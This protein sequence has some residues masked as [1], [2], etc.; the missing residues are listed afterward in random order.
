MKSERD[1]TLEAVE[2]AVQMEIDGKKF[3]QKA[4]KECDNKVAKRLY[5]WLATEEEGH[6]RTFERIYAAIKDKKGWPEISLQP[7][8]AK[9]LVTFFSA[10]RESACPV[11]EAPT[12]ELE[13]AAKAMDMENKTHEFYKSRGAEAAYDAE[14]RLYT[15]LAAEEQ[16]HYLALVDYREYLIDPAGW[17]RKAE[18]HS[19]DGG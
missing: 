4:S 12:T 9:T 18:H 13:V 8:E 15:S 6:R 17:F 5:D 19:L 7:K 2:F 1:R 14:R 3:Y 11:D 10:A 16:G